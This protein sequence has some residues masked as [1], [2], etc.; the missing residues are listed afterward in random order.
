MS[1]SRSASPSP[2]ATPE[3]RPSQERENRFEQVLVHHLLRD[4]VT[5]LT[6]RDGT[7]HQFPWSPEHEVRTGVLGVTFRPAAETEVAADDTETIG[8]DLDVAEANQPSESTVDEE[9]SVTT[10]AAPIDNRGV[11]GVDFVV[12]GDAPALQLTIDVNFALYH[13]LLPE[14]ADI[15]GEANVQAA[16]VT[17]NRNRRPAVA[18]NPNWRRDN[19]HVTVNMTVPIDRDESEASTDGYMPGG[20]PLETD[21]IEAIRTHYE[22]PWAL[23]KLT[24]NQTIP[25]ADALVT[26]EHL[27]QALAAR[28]DPLWQPSWPLPRVD[29]ATSRTA[30]GEIAVSVSIRNARKVTGRQIQDLSIYD[31]RMSVVIEESLHLTSQRLRFADEDVRYGDVATVVG[32]GRG[33]VAYPGEQPNSV[34]AETLPVH[35]QSIAKP[36]DHGADLHFAALAIDHWPTLNTIGSAMRS[37]LRS[38]DSTGDGSD[39]SRGQLEALRVKFEAEVERFELGVDLLHA[40]P[41]L[42]RAFRLANRSFALAKGNDAAWRLFQLV[43]IVT[44][45]GALAGRESPDDPRLRAELESVDVLWFPTGGGKTEAYL[46]LIMVALFFDRLR[47][48]LRGT[49]GWLLFPLR[50]LSVQQLARVTEILHHAEKTRLTEQVEGDPFTLGYLVGSGNTPN[51]LY[52]PE[53]NSWWRGL[54]WFANLNPEERDARRLV[55][56]CPE[57]KDQNSVGLDADIVR[58][59]LEHVCRRCG[60]H[61]PIYPS[62]EEVTRY[63]PSVVVSTVDK[64]TAFSRNGELT[65]FHHGPRKC[66]PD[67]GWYTHGGC[68]VEGCRSDPSTHISPTGFKDPVPALWIQDELHLVREDLGVF[69]GHYHTLLVELARGAGLTPS[70]VIAATA[71]IEQYE[72]QLRQVYGR[73]PR[74]YPIGGPTLQRSFYSEEIDD[75]RR[76]YLGVLP[77]GGGTA[78]VDVAGSILQQLVE[79][80]HRLTDDPEPLRSVLS[81]HGINTDSDEVRRRLFDY[82]LALAYVNSKA[83]GVTVLDDVNRLSQD[84]INEGSDRIRAE[85]VMGETPL[86]ELA[87]VVAD[88]QSATEQTPRAERIRALV[89]TA[90]ISHGVDLDRL[91]FEVLAG[92]PPSYAQY[93]QATARA[94]RRFV[95]LVV[96][97]FDRNNRRETSMFQSFATTHAALERMVEP[98]PVNRFAARAVERTLPGI[99]CA[100]LWDETRNARWSNDQRISMTRNFRP[101][102]NTHAATLGPALRTRIGA[103]YRCPVPDPGRNIDEQKLI[104]DAVS[105]WDNVEL[106]RMQ[107]FQSDLLTELFTRPAMNSLRDVDAPTD[108][109]GG[110]RAQQVVERILD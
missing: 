26:V 108:F 4:V 38:W 56:A 100:L 59:R 58:Q 23:C 34:V 107:Q 85:Y 37:F 31:V 53:Q 106:Q 92:M 33:C 97:V 63:Q 49:S 40:D 74:L 25:V 68:R 47:G 20:D 11:I 79:E 46:G 52:Q 16:A 102:W 104:D 96:S 71:T 29:V 93:I 35:V 105:R 44:E 72:D 17:G 10:I 41:R 86:S 98:V 83:H 50:M 73:T 77:S 32:R 66:C 57:C 30:N 62:D 67:H 76:I 28:R 84:L 90:V 12:S 82:E 65:S 75:I 6:D 109:I 15:N 88:I 7:F 51:R 54:T 64:L 80:I 89:G 70:K 22:D 95:G 9:E 21:V 60:H 18:V 69:A 13:P 61:L 5:A 39:E 43:F 24:R 110:P 2:F 103:A 45:L 1:L 3:A 27:A 101:W 19:R 91:N 99:V 48:K 14:F 55:G 94:G 78:K 42:D 8:T 36:L 81:S 87:A